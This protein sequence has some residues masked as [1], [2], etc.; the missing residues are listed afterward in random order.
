MITLA[1]DNQYQIDL[2]N[3]N[4][5]PLLRYLKQ[6]LN[7]SD[8]ILQIKVQQRDTSPPTRTFTGNDNYKNL[9]EK[10]PLLEQFRKE[11]GLEIN[12]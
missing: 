2:V 4:K 8:V 3:Q 10:N 12:F 9:V 5:E 1:V 7:N 11:L 6:Q